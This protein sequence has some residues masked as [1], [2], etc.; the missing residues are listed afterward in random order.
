MS[1]LK[2]LRALSQAA[3]CD[4]KLYSVS[5]NYQKDLPGTIPIERKLPYEV[6]LRYTLSYHL[7]K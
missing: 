2:E 3:A 7:I 6:N 5:H 4:G 1:I